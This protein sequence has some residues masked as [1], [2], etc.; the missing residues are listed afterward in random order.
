MSIETTDIID[1]L[2]G[3]A[4]ASALH[5]VRSARAVARDNAQKSYEALFLPVDDTLVSLAE[6][7]AVAAFVAGLHGDAGV[8]AFYRERL[9][10]VAPAA[11]TTAIADEVARGATRGPYGNYPA[12]PL[13]VENVA[14][15]VYEVTEANHAALGARLTAALEHAHLL[16]FRPRD[17]S[18][19]ALQD[20]LDA[21]WST[22]GIVT[23]SQLVAF[24]AFQ[25]RV[26]VG[27]RA[28]AVSQSDSAVSSAA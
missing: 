25:I 19:E 21:G 1:H 20:L 3:I 10:A 22:D 12:G 9:S 4:P 18:P 16:V 17:S 7:L 23:L 5:V 14:G 24:L 13:T 2:A 28:L 15:I 27:L 11:L 6:R 26:I 8:A